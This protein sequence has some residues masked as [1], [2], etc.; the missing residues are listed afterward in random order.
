MSYGLA[1]KSLAL[2]GLTAC[3]T[4]VGDSASTYFC[5]GPASKEIRV[6][7]NPVRSEGPGSALASM[8]STPG[9]LGTP[10]TSQLDYMRWSYAQWLEHRGRD[11]NFLFDLKDLGQIT[12]PSP[13]QRILTPADFSERQQA[14]IRSM[15]ELQAS[16]K[17]TRRDSKKVFDD[18]MTAMK[19][20]IAK[21]RQTGSDPAITP[22][23]LYSFAMESVAREKDRGVE[24]G[25]FL[26][27]LQDGR[28]MTAVF[29]SSTIHMDLEDLQK[30]LLQPLI[31]GKNVAWK[32]IAAVQFFHTHPGPLASPLTKSDT[33]LARNIRQL[34]LSQGGVKIESHVY[35]IAHD[36]QGVLIFHHGIK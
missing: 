6:C 3:A 26:I 23:M 11:M 2:I 33:D 19:S 1:A 35:A 8:Q 28:V 32:D 22:D 12:Q 27:T 18:S 20:E 36:A 34:F 16:P 21:L 4:N 9:E 24:I 14:L 31:R 30:A 10:F 25:A 17:F 29:T 5:R 15:I 7:E 13:E